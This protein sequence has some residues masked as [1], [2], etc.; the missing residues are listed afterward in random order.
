MNTQNEAQTNEFA[1]TR[2][3]LNTSIRQ[4]ANVN[5]NLAKLHQYLTPLSKPAPS[6]PS[7]SLST[8]SEENS[9][10]EESPEPL[11]EDTD[12]LKCTNVVEEVT[13]SPIRLL[14]TAMV[15]EPPPP[16]QFSV[17]GILIDPPR[18][19]EQVPSGHTHVSLF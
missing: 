19:S 8:A 13:P 17:F 3:T 18:F 4:L 15:S 9:Y 10:A 11:L 16:S 14:Y 7:P 2:R 6:S 12:D 5:C 1:I